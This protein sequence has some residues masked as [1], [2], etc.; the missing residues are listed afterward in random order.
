MLEQYK[1]KALKSVKGGNAKLKKKF[2]ESITNNIATQDA[3]HFD[4]HSFQNMMQVHWDLSQNKTTE[5]INIKI[6]CPVMKESNRRKTVINIIC[7]E[8]AFL[9]DTVA[10][11]INEHK[12][13][14]QFLIHPQIN[15]SYDNK[16]NLESINT[17]TDS[18][19]KG[20]EQSHMHIQIHE[21]LP[22]QAIKRLEE[23]ITSSIR[24]VY[25]A[26]KDWK[27]MLAHL[28]E[29]RRELELAQ[30][31]KP[32]AVVREYCDFLD[33]LYD[34]NF[35]L[36]GYAE[37]KFSSTDLSK[38]TSKTIATLGLL[39]NKKS[40]GGIDQKNE[41]FPRNLKYTKNPL[42]PVVVSKTKIC[43]TVHRRVP[44]DVITIKQYNDNGDVI[45]EKLFLGLFTSVTY[46]RSVHDIPYLRLKVKKIIKISRTKEGSHNS[47]AL[48]HILEKYPR[49]ELFQTETSQLFTIASNILRLQERQRTALFIRKDVFSD[50]ISCLVYVPRERFGT[51]LRQQIVQTLEKELNGT[52]NSFF[53]SMD[54]SVFAR[55]LFRVDVDPKNLPKI[56]IKNIEEK[57][58]Q[59]G[60]TWEEKLSYAFDKSKYNEEKA[61]YL[62]YKYG[63]AFPINYTDLHTPEQALFD[64]KKIEQALESKQ[65]QLNLYQSDNMDNHELRLKIYNIKTP[66]ILSDVMP[67]L[68]N[69]GVR[70]ISEL[71][72]EITP[73]DSEESIWVHDFLLEIPQENNGAELKKVKAIFEVAFTQIWYHKMESDKLN[74]LILGAE[75]PWRDIIILRAYTKYMKQ[76]RTPHSQ[77]AIIDA[78]TK[79]TAIS[80]DLINLFHAKFDPTK[81]SKTNN[82][83]NKIIAQLENVDAL[84]EDRIIRTALNLFNATLRTNFYQTTDNG[85]PKD[86]L[87]LKLDSKEIDTLPKPKPFREIFVYSAAV[88]GVHLRGDKIAR[89]GLRWS[90][91][92]EDYRTEV[93]G[94]MKAQMVKNSV[95]VPMGSKGGF[96][97][98]TP[99]KT[100]DEYMKVGIECYK[101]FIRGLLDITDNLEG[102]T[103]IPPD[104]TK[105]LD[106]DDPYLVVA[107]DKGTATFSAN[108]LSQDYGFWLDDAFASGGSAGYDHKKMGITARGAWESVKLHFRQLNHNTQTQPF[109]VVGIGDMGGDVFGNGMLL[110]DQIR[111]IG[112][113]NH[114]HIFCDPEPDPKTS[115]KERQRLFDKVA[116]WNQYD[117]SLLSKGG[118]IYS[119]ADK[120]LKLTPEIQ[121]RF[122]IEESEVPPSVLMKAILKSRTDLIWFGGIGTYIKSKKENH[123]DAGDKANDSLRINAEELRAK[124][125][126]EGANLG[127]TQLGRIEF[128]QKGG[129]INTDFIDNSG[130]VDSSDHEVNI[131][132]LLST[133][134]KNKKHDM[135]L[136]ARNTLL[137]KMTCD[138]EN[139]VLRHNYQQAQAVSLA[140]MQ[141]ANHLQIHDEF[142]QDMEREEGLDRAIEFLP[143]LEEIQKRTLTNKGLTRPELSILISYAKITLTKDLLATKTPD[144]PDMQA[145][146]FDYFPAILRKTYKKEIKTH[147]LNRE[148]IAM[149]IANSLINRLGP[150]FIKSTM[151]KTGM[152]AAKIVEAYMITREIF[153]L[154]NMWDDIEALD[155]KAPANVQLAAMQ[156]IAKLAEFSINWFLTRHGK[157]LNIAKDIKT[158]QSSIKTIS[159]N[160]Q[161][162][163][164]QDIKKSLKI[165]TDSY[166]HDALPTALANKIAALPILNSALD[167]TQI[168][169]ET[170]LEIDK[171][172]TT[173]FNLGERF[174]IDWLRIQA[175]FKEPTNNWDKEATTGLISQLYS[176]QA[177]LTIRILNDCKSYGSTCGT[178]IESW[179][180]KHDHLINELDPFFEKIHNAGTL[181]LPMLVIAEQRLR[182]LYGG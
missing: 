14:I 148:I 130:G 16:N 117:Q 3:D 111:L 30:T 64:I 156:E 40:T 150:T 163:V 137:E 94:L 134:M 19:V 11:T 97:V 13:L 29:A 132:I 147:K 119:R 7:K 170:K 68:G 98:K 38:A 100:R 20:R 75:M 153:G 160:L 109:D 101:T 49:D 4:E 73:N 22:A 128:C 182:N 39:N 178:E 31:E 166:T 169:N 74:K 116:G 152:S 43:T 115:F 26:N 66:I 61:T 145:W 55:G 118:K 10:A 104:N 28:R 58:Q 65:L 69:L 18:A 181:D 159:D 141:A 37:Y 8:A 158:Y 42:P 70:A 140:E 103:V 177:G 157:D 123:T 44:M 171:I 48:R 76:A 149:A 2:I 90:D 143:D 126:G 93:L 167:I 6:D 62:T 155:N 161:N 146:L 173:Y 120:S 63:E 121:K 12:Y 79:H 15:V 45:G 87:S 174:H 127:V 53:T 21:A 52:C 179:I 107:A 105:R 176:C 84:N 5:D 131:K 142:I 180:E 91:R 172:A 114:L 17:D 106:A 81:A 144:N 34:N 138:I 82:F 72:F 133:V 122:D 92:H 25:T 99:T 77:S 113:F 78:L 162:L 88:E 33:Y 54:D 51:A 135:D 124:V 96:V 32:M 129:K 164:A 9:V 41:G 57:L 1:S 112:A 36:L 165:R 35:T 125:I 27:N 56:N 67:I 108:A 175:R 85:H 151:K 80:R 46:S 139:H 23:D 154:R 60:Q 47:K 59:L 102:D 71:P 50:Y 24:D 136:K 86:Y 110:S 95:I 83:E 89:G 168:A